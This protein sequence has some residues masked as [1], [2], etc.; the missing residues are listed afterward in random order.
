MNDNVINLDPNR[1]E[2]CWLDVWNYIQEC[3]R[4][5]IGLNFPFKTE[6]GSEK[7]MWAL[8]V[9]M[10]RQQVNVCR[11]DDRGEYNSELNLVFQDHDANGVPGTVWIVPVNSHGADYD[12]DYR[13]TIST[14]V[15]TI[16]NRWVGFSQRGG[17]I[18][19]IFRDLLCP[20][21]KANQLA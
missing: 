3:E 13:E 21:L 7:P 6:S 10:H 5:A 1:T 14:S 15:C 16:P 18:K 4:D 19:E 17:S 2:P 20:T 11:R 12:S 9:Y 8:H